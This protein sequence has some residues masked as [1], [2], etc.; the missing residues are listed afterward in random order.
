LFLLFAWFIPNRWSDSGYIDDL[1]FL[2]SLSFSLLFI[3]F[4]GFDLRWKI[5]FV[6]INGG[7][8]FVEIGCGVYVG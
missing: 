5:R 4:F 2:L 7:C 8:R 1:L 3:L 6:L